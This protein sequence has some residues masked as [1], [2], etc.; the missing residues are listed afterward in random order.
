MLLN[1]GT[2]EDSWESLDNKEIKLVNPK[3]NQPWIFT[4]RTDAEV[5]APT[6]HLVQRVNSLERILS[7]EILWNCKMRW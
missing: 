4:G 5:E 3:G 6:D 7:W 2:G 1:C